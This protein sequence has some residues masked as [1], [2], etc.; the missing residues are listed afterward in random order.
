MEDE[1]WQLVLGDTV[2]WPGEAVPLFTDVFAR[3]GKCYLHLSG[4]IWVF[5]YPE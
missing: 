2:Y 1:V 3:V 4:R 5:W